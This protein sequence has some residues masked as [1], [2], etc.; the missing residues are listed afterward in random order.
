MKSNLIFIP[1][2]AENS[3]E[4]NNKSRLILLLFP[5]P[6]FKGCLFLL[7]PNVYLLR[8]RYFISN[9]PVR[10]FKLLNDSDPTCFANKIVYIKK[11]RSP[12]QS[13][14]PA[15]RG[16]PYSLLS[17]VDLST[18]LCHPTFQL[19]KWPP[20]NNL[21]K[22][23]LCCCQYFSQPLIA[24]KVVMANFV[25]FFPAAKPYLPLYPIAFQCRTVV[26]NHLTLLVIKVRCL[27]SHCWIPS[28]GTKY[29]FNSIKFHK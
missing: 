9:V 7:S 2:T 29:F 24:R 17:P 21:K 10:P 5:C 15:S 25:V 20:K 12:V 8:I 28:A 11:K 22:V 19:P 13:W 26:Q 3:L 14:Q 6:N 27:H 4:S 1:L 16:Y 18:Y 23:L